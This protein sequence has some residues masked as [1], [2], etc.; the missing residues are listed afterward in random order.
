MAE[1]GGSYGSGGSYGGGSSYGGGYGG[2]SYGRPIR[3]MFPATCA[4]CGVQTE[5]P[6]RPR[7]DRPVYCSSCYEKVRPPR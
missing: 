7:E 1:G 5:V 4:Q 3:Q 6:F 2:G